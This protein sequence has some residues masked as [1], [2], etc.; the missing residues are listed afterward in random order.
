MA[1]LT[2]DS[3]RAGYGGKFAVD[4][5]THE[6]SDGA[7]VALIGPN[8]SGKSTL[9]KA[10]CRLSQTVGGR[11]LV[12]DADIAG[13]SFAEL[14]RWVAYVPQEESPSF[15]FTAFQMVLTGRN[16]HSTRFF[17]SEHD[18]SVAQKAMEACDCWELRDRVVAELSG[19]EKQRVS[20]ARAVAQETKI[21]LLDE[22]ISHLDVLHQFQLRDLLHR[23]ADDG[24]IILIAI[25]DLQ[26]A[27]RLANQVILLNSGSVVSVKPPG[28]LISGKELEDVFSVKFEVTRS[29]S[30]FEQFVAT[31]PKCSPRG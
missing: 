4:A 12:S 17:E 25:H 16:P 2:F 21:L 11:I 1:T 15:S 5:G 20:I 6:F 31:E 26:W 3:L 28:E 19:G 9:L 13:C 29:E 10:V 18:H 24:T 27:F 23:L 14:A 7:I 22:P 8:G 30:G